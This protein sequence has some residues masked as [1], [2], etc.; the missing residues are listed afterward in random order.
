MKR[1]N[2]FKNIENRYKNKISL[3]KPLILRLDGK[4]VTKIY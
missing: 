1:F 2:F 3:K 4:G